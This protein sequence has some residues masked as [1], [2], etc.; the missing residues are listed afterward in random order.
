M[1]QGMISFEEVDDF[2]YRLSYESVFEGI[3]EISIDLFAR[4]QLSDDFGMS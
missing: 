1:P 4:G 2:T 3:G